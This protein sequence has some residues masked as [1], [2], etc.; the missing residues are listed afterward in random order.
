ML[1][2]E[3]GHLQRVCGKV[4]CLV[5]KDIKSMIVDTLKVIFV[6]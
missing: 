6:Y 3:G 4:V 2:M 5:A 1:L